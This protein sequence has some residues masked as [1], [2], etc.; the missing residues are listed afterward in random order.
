MYKKFQNFQQIFLKNATLLSNDFIM[1]HVNSESSC[2]NMITV[3]FKAT[4]IYLVLLQ[5]VGSNH[6]QVK[7]IALWDSLL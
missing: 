5:A 1:L 6:S 3:N 7:C 4:L 2:P